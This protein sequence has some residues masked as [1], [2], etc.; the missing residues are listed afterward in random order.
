M[1]QYGGWEQI[2]PLGEGG[3]SKVSL[4][5][6]PE[7]RAIREG[8]IKRIVAPLRTQAYE[9]KPVLRLEDAPD[10][11]AAIADYIRADLPSELGAL[12]IFKIPPTTQKNMSPIPESEE[13][14]AVRRLENEIKALQHGWPG[15]AKLLAFNLDER[16]MITEYFP[17]GTLEDHPLKYKG[18]ALAATKAFRSLVETLEHIHKEK[19]VHRDIKPA[20]VFIR[21][22]DE[23]VLGDFGIVFIPDQIGRL[24]KSH[25]RVGPRDY[26]P[27]WANLGKRLENVE[28]NFDVYMLGKLLWSMIDGRPVVMR[29]Y[30]QHPNY[31]EF[32]LTHTFEG[33]PDMHLINELISKCVVEF[34]SKCLPSAKELLSG[35]NETIQILERKGQLLS[36]AVPR[37]C[38]ICGKGI[39][40][41]EAGIGNNPAQFLLSLQILRAHQT[42]DHLRVLASQPFVCN[43]C[44]HIQFFKKHG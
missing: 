37:P 6:S 39:Y 25:E 33:D 27:Q 23:L 1:Q 44:G 35:V 41:P 30:V 7:R 21:N 15:L 42:Y 2:R 28:A 13:Y 38:R 24:T 32:D 36:S 43:F 3:Q 18:Q 34:P 12:K 8:A 26:M 29:E 22:D 20:N 14:E 40:Q 16:W 11:A 4:V 17:N 19:Y 9:S 5:R 31:P 10:F